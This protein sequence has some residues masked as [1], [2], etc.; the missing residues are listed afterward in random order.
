[1]SLI[2]GDQVPQLEFLS[3][4]DEDFWNLFGKGMSKEKNPLSSFCIV[5]CVT[6]IVGLFHKNRLLYFSSYYAMARKL[7]RN[8]KILFG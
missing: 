8:S 1:M 3:T 7:G 4:W 6:Y 2:N 5:L